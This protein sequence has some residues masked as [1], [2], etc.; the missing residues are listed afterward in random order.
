MAVTGPLAI[1]ISGLQANA[2]RANVAANNIVN[3]NTAGFQAGRVRTSSVVTAGSSS[4][5]QAQVFAAGDVDVATE[6]SRLILAETAYKAAAATIRVAEDLAQK[7]VD[8]I[9]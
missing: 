8:I 3:Q 2:L 6:F 4:G 7:T 9:A 1:A 5:V